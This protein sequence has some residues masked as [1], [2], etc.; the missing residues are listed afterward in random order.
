MLR[1]CILLSTSMCVGDGKG[2]LK[3]GVVGDEDVIY[4]QCMKAKE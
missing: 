1:H 3:K 2:V 4:D